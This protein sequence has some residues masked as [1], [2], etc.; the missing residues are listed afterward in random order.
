MASSRGVG[1]FR[2]MFI[3]IPNGNERGIQLIPV[4]DIAT[5]D[6]YEKIK[7]VTAQEVITGHRFPVELAAIIPNGGTRGDPIKFD[8]VY[9]KNEVIP[10]CEMFMDAVNGDPEVPES[11]HL[12]FNL[13][14]IAT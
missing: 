11:L 8:Y 6:E 5:K 4:G 3:N 10:A 9:C 14:N 2:S 13:D 1:N 12:T 7:N